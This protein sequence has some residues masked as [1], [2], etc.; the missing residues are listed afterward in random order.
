M[1]WVIIWSLVIMNWISFF[2]L[3]LDNWRLRKFR[4][5][6]LAKLQ[7]H[8][9]TLDSCQELINT[10]LAKGYADMDDLRKVGDKYKAT[11]GEKGEG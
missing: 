1:V 3:H 10:I 6:A 4:R 2:F 11:I 7:Q 5:E 8:E 9:P